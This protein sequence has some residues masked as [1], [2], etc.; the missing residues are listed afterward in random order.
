M[1]PIW[2][3]WAAGCF[4]ALMV[5]SVC[6]SRGSSQDLSTDLALLL[7][8]VIPQVSVTVD[9]A[10]TFAI[11]PRFPW[12]YITL[13]CTGAEAIDTITGG[14]QGTILII[15]DGDTDCTLNDDN[16]AT[17]ADAID[18][19]G[20]AN[21]VGAVAKDIALIYNGASWEELYESDN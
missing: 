12:T 21:D 5:L 13:A 17:A 11:T 1:I 14:R 20:A 19:T 9:G 6:V 8:G 10:T 7:R 2:K 15:A 16:A 3:R 4:L 18:L